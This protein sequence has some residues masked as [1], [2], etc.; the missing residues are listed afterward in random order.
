MQHNKIKQEISNENNLHKVKVKGE[1]GRQ[2]YVV[3]VPSLLRS[4]SP[5]GEGAEHNA[6]MKPT[7]ATLFLLTLLPMQDAV[8]HYAVALKVVTEPLHTRL[9][10]SPQ[11]N[12]RLPTK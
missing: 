6:H 10:Q 1:H 5:F 9:G 2:G 7:R 4:T 11:L 3:E 8:I 12:W